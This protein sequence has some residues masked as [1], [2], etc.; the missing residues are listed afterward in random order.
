TDFGSATLVLQ[1]KAAENL[2]TL[3]H[4][5]LLGCLVALALLA[6]YL[7]WVRPRSLRVLFARVPTA[8]ATAIALGVVALLGFALNDSGI[9]IPGMMAAV[10]EA[11]VVV[12]LAR[13]VF[14][15]PARG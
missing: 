15:A 8:R 13:V 9:T 3:G 6:A 7:F 4:S 12:L 1:R 5:L 14:P 11:T 2:S 10:I